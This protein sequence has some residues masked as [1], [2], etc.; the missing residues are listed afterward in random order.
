MDKL[1]SCMQQLQAT[2]VDTFSAG[3]DN[4][5]S[6]VISKCEYYQSLIYSSNFFNFHCPFM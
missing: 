5:V 3:Q 1:M 6:L 4:Q 2:A